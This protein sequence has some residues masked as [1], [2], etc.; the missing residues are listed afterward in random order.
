MY[1]MI[2]QAEFTFFSSIHQSTPE[3][4]GSGVLWEEEK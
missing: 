4:Y 2:Y 3:A 1:E